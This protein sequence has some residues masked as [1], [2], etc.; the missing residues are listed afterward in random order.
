MEM[1]FQLGNECLRELTRMDRLMILSRRLFWEWQNLTN[2]SFSVPVQKVCLKW[3][4][5]RHLSLEVD[6][7]MDKKSAQEGQRS[8][9]SNLEQ[10]TSYH[11]G[12]QT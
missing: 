8:N 3:S 2:E 12:H 11:P 1:N 10:Y 9:M 6:G 7:F 5:R 4:A